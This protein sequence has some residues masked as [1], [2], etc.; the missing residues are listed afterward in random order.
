MT[1]ASRVWTI[2]DKT[3][4]SLLCSPQVKT[5]KRERTKGRDEVAFLGNSMHREPDQLETDQEAC[6]GASIGVS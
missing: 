5:N 4:W 2:R 1:S 3:I 6:T